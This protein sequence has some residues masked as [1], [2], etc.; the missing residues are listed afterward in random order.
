MM[1]SNQVALSRKRGARLLLLLLLIVGLPLVI[2]LS[3]PRTV[4]S[5]GT[6]TTC[7]G[8]AVPWVA[9]IWGTSS[10]DVF[11]VGSD[12]IQHFDGSTWRKVYISTTGP[13]WSVWGS[14]GSDVFAVGDGGAVLHYDGASWTSMTSGVADRLSCV[15]GTSSSNVFAAGESSNW[16]PKTLTR[17][18]GT[19]PII[20]YDGTRWTAMDSGLTGDIFDVW[21]TSHSDVFAVGF[22]AGSTAAILHYDG[23][24]WSVMDAGIPYDATLYGVWGDSHSDVFAVGSN[25][26]ILHYDGGE[27]K[28]MMI[29]NNRVLE[30][31]WGTSDS[32]VFVAG[33][34]GNL[35]HYNGSLWTAMNS[36]AGMWA[37]FH[38]VWGTSSLN[39]FLAGSGGSITCLLPGAAPV[40]TAVTPDSGSQDRNMKV[41]FMGSGL[42]LVTGA[43]FGPGITVFGLKATS[44]TQVMA[45][46]NIS[47]SAE[48]GLRDVSVTTLSGT[49]TLPNALTVVPIP[50]I[51]AIS[52][53]HA[54]QGQALSV[55]IT[56]TNLL[57]VT[58]VDLGSG[59]TMEELTVTSDTEVTASITVD[60]DAFPDVRTV[61]VTAP[62]GTA[63]LPDGFRVK[64]TALQSAW[65]WIVLI[66]G[67][68]SAV[69][70][71]EY[72]VGKRR[73]SGAG[74]LP[75]VQSDQG[76][77]KKHGLRACDIIGIVMGV[78][79][80][81]PGLGLAVYGFHGPLYLLAGVGLLVISV[82][83]FIP[84]R[85]YERGITRAVGFAISALTTGV[86][87]AI[88]VFAGWIAQLA[89]QQTDPSFQLFEGMVTLF[90]TAV[91]GFSIGCTV[92]LLLKLRPRL[93]HAAIAIA[94]GVGVGALLV[95]LMYL[96]HFFE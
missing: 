41:T 49:S 65:V 68:V 34:E 3:N 60:K 39:V 88:A 5:S 80:L 55:T 81:C 36:N 91:A 44:D 62:S 96:L 59:I 90:L 21:G 87:V 51:S 61:K 45:S 38:D 67:I 28:R 64:D 17:H 7:Y 77:A 92:V 18:Y 82:G 19:A 13:L 95:R 69:W 29:D 56:G 10:S 32:D 6:W 15:W 8:T 70:A 22:A 48:V 23:S 31:V 86:S 75:Q 52:P 66:V 46:I 40:L 54:K 37:S 47:R 20:H 25:G 58:Q 2:Q 83:L 79:I 50:T 4:A 76:H 73:E 27:W 74:S 93:A 30:A 35:L 71:G 14:S 33:E 84:S 11:T 16:T 42:S 94:A 72:F 78:L 53:G 89:S 26:T 12:G 24:S 43:D 9:G 57:G 63:M 1:S 85:H